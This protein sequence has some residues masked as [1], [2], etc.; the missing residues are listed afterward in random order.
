MGGIVKSMPTEYTLLYDSCGVTHLM[1][2]TIFSKDCT[3]IYHIPHQVF[4]ASRLW[5]IYIEALSGTIR[6]T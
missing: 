5:F 6:S 1:H 3:S 4:V 2:D